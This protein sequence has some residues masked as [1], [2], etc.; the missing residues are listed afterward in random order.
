M[1]DKQKTWLVSAVGMVCVMTIGVFTY[2]VPKLV[3][4]IING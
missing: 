2:L 1:N 4:E 3:K